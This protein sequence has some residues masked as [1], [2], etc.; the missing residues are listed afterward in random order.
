MTE[1]IRLKYGNTACYLFQGTKK[2]LL[3]T[4]WAGTL[5]RFFHELGQRGLT[6]QAIDYL[7][8]THYHPDHMGLAADLMTLGIR[9]VVLDC[10]RA[11]LH[12]SDYVFEKEHNQ[13]FRPIND[14]AIRLVKL[15]NSRTFLQHCGINGTILS[16]PG[17][18]A[19]SISVVLD[20]GEAF[21]GDL[22]PLDQVALYHN[23]VLTSSWRKLKAANVHQVHFA[24]Y[25]DEVVS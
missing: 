9:L 14:Q 18:S 13:F 11:Y 19:D 4:D 6:A 10:Q 2:I 8:I 1:V 21:V 23:P 12:Q 20:D 5:P 3:D 24:H 17:H 22:Y 7:L 25:A 15:T 16:T